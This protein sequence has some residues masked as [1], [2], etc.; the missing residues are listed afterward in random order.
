MERPAAPALAPAFPWTGP[1]ARRALAPALLFVLLVVA[2]FDDPYRPTFGLDPSWSMALGHFLQEGRQLGPDVVFT[3]GPLGFVL[4]NQLPD[5]ALLEPLLLARLVICAVF[6]VVVLQGARRLTPL[7]RVPY[8]AFFGLVTS[9]SPGGSEGVEALYWMIIA[10]LGLGLV[11]ERAR[12][13]LAAAGAHALVL[14]LLAGIKFTFFIGAVFFVLLAALQSVLRGRRLRALCLASCFTVGYVCV[15]LGCG[16]RIG[17]LGLY[18]RNSWDLARGY[19]AAMALHTPAYPFWLSMGTLVG[20]AIYVVLH[21]GPS[22][23]RS[24]V[25]FPL[26]GLS[27]FLYLTWKHGFV[28]SDGHMLFFFITALLPV[29]GFPAL[30]GD[31]GRGQRVAQAVLVAT[32]VLAVWG[33]YRVDAQLKRGNVLRAGPA[34]FQRKLGRQARL[35][36]GL[37]S[38]RLEYAR[39]LDAE[40]RRLDLPATRS[41][42]GRGS[43]DVLGYEQAIALYNGFR[44]R[45][46]PM[47][48]SHLVFTPY[49][50]RLNEDFYRSDRAPA[51]ALLKIQTIDGRFPALDD[52]LLLRSFLYRYD[53]AHTEHGFQLWKQ[54]ARPLRE[55]GDPLRVLGRATLR[56]NEPWRLGSLRD[57]R[58][59]AT[60]RLRPSWAGQVR[61]ALYKPPLVT[62]VIEDTRGRHSAFRLTLPQAAIG[63]ILNPVIEDGDDYLCFAAGAAKRQVA[64][65]TLRVARPDTGFF[66]A[67]AD[68]ELAE[69]PP[70]PRRGSCDPIEPE[71][72]RAG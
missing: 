3:Y 9:L 30:L 7:R 61:D 41:V 71:A 47:L 60:L 22:R 50:A 36:G 37:G 69:L 29:V 65:L 72:P 67:S 23:R 14:S 46:R 33:I 56:L 63:F 62:L 1:S 53:Y 51:Y 2:F 42:I 16:Q 58:L 48:Q 5:V 35:L 20:L 70:A 8:L 6:A 25:L 45:S 31:G 39:D 54:R 12:D 11:H 4:S 17:N 24:G 32:A 26:V 49:L 68:L 43:I 40:R 15:W 34:D 27:V 13:S 10:C 38:Y 55:G 44:Y 18:L 64:A 19:H 52:P 21:L 66:S 28:R 59:W 57:H